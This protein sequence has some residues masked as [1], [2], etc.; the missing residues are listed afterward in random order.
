MIVVGA[1]LLAAAWWVSHFADLVVKKRSGFSSTVIMAL[2]AA[3]M[4][5]LNLLL[6]LV[7]S[8]PMSADRLAAR[9]NILRSRVETIRNNFNPADTLIV[10]VYDEQ[11]VDYY[12]PGYEHFGFDPLVS[13]RVTQDLGPGVKRIVIFEDYLEPAEV[14]ASGCLQLALDQTLQYLDRQPGQ[15]KVVIDWGKKKVALAGG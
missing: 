14:I 2:L 15:S 5:A 9:D 6:F 12:L 1:A 13:E 4:V 7:L 3:G 11:Q 8:P 10:A